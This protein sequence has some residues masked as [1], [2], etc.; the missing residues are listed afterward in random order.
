MADFLVRWAEF[1]GGEY[2]LL[3]PSRAEKDQWS[4]TNMIEYQSGLLGVRPGLKSLV[5]DWQGEPGTH[6]VV[7]GPLGFDVQN[8]NL[9]I[10]LQ[11]TNDDWATFKIDFNTGVATP[12][13]AY[14]SPPTEFIRYAEGAQT[15]YGLINGELWKHEPGGMTQITLPAGIK[16]SGLVRWNYWL[17]GVDQDTP[18]RI[19]HST[20]TVNG[21]EFDNWGINNYLDVGS[22]LP[23]L[24]LRPI[25]NTLYCGKQ[26]GWWGVSGILGQQA[27]VRFRAIGNGP[28]TDR[29]CTV[30]TDNRL[31]YWPTE[32][33]PAWFNGDRVYLD[34]DYQLSGYDTEFICDTVIATPTGKRLLMIGELSGQPDGEEKSGM[35][36]WDKAWSVHEFDQPI[37]GAVPQDVRAGTKM[38]SGVTFLIRRPVVITDPVEI[39]SFQ[40]DAI[41]PSHFDDPFAAPIDFEGTELVTG[42]VDLPAHWD[43]QGRMVLVKNLIVQF[44]KWP[45][46]IDGTLNR[47][48]ATVV[49][50]GRYEGGSAQTNS[51]I[52]TEPSDRANGEGTDDSV[53]MSFGD[54]GWSAGFQVKFNKLRGVAIREVIA[55]CEVRMARI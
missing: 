2:G 41:R 36:L 54:Q 51:L 48:E 10:P 53:R 37:S 8:E 21:P 26:D 55:V 33:V 47:L 29:G 5:I 18:Y 3:D 14:T 23:I 40:L 16:L 38:P 46:G 34:K 49:P 28:A 30:T 13:P 39:G 27:S 1:G 44:R 42:Q 20:V 43:G 4:G 11:L 52:W 6:P 31:L 17:I 25:F 35:L 24:T 32:S 9:L 7:P 12:F 15:L 50:L 19:W 22:N 45:S